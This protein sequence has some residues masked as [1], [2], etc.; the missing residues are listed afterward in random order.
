[1]P[2][3]PGT[4]ARRPEGPGAPTGRSTR[5]TAAATTPAASATPTGTIGRFG[6]CRP[7]VAEFLD[8]LLLEGRLERDRT[9]RCRGRLGRTAAPIGTVAR[10]GVVTPGRPR[11]SAPVA[12]AAA[13][14]SLGRARRGLAGQGQRHLALRVDVIDPHLDRLI[15][16][17]EHSLE[18]R[19][20]PAP[21]T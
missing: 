12:A 3:A 19:A 4:G 13:V 20:G 18:G 7:Q 1:M 5:S 21:T 6:H 17:M 8:Q 9:G 11:A 15:R 16:S 10:V 14:V 2:G